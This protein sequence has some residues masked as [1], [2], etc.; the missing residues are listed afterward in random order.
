M[1]ARL[2]KGGHMRYKPLDRGFNVAVLHVASVLFPAGFDV[3]D[4][5]PQTYEELTGMLDAGG[6]MV[7]WSGASENTIYA[8]PEVNYAF[9]AWHD[10]CHWRGRHRFD[11]E[12][13]VA[14]CNMQADH[15]SKLYGCN[16]RWRN[17]LHAE[18]IGQQLYLYR[19]GYYPKDQRTFVEAYLADPDFFSLRAA[20]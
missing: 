2:N 18:T 15:L 16:E 11:P 3:A 10:W 19:F 1:G 7:V 9:R 4:Q 14:V 12:G 13:E 5:A 6:R 17:I 8:D 20:E